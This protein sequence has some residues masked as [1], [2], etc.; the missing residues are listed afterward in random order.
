VTLFDAAGLVGVAL[1]LCAY[2]G[3]Q[4]RWLDPLRPRSLLMNLVGASLIMVSMIRAFN[5][6][7]FTMEAAWAIVAIYGLVRYALTR[8]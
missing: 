4:A 2:A 6:A 8:R 7:A 3:A 1:I 5:L